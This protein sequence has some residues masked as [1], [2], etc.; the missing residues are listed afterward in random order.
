MSISTGSNETKIIGIV[1]PAFNEGPVIGQVLDGL[2]RYMK[3]AGKKLRLLII[4]VNDGSRDNT[5]QE[6]GKRE[7]VILINHII[8]SGA[9]AA[10]RTGLHYA[11]QSGC[12]YA[13]TMDA[14]GQHSARDVRKLVKA[15][16]NDEADLVIGSRLKQYS[17]NMPLSKKI[18]NLGLSIITFLL[19][20]V[21]ASD[22]QSG[23]RA[24]NKRAVETAEFHSNNYAHCSEMLWKVHQA[25]LRIKEVPIEAI[26]TDYSVSRGQK[27]FSGAFEI[28]RQLV[29]RRLL[30]IIQ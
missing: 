18:G 21:Y 14:D 9:G 25:K 12:S 28:I 11:L 26:Y 13:I 10:T 6:T 2:P 27:N 3:I 29:R 19:L 16:I 22:S 1:L 17:G 23:L 30:H 24:F 7:D 8:N 4:V 20:G 5:A 15:I